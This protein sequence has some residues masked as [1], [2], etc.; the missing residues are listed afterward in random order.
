[1]QGSSLKSVLEKHKALFQPGLG[2]LK[3]G[4]AKITVDP[5]AMPLKSVPQSSFR[6]TA[7]Y[8]TSKEA[9]PQSS[10]VLCRRH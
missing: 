3:G 7:I 1:M 8:S 10:S 9:Y 2:T 6:S 4:K 5:E